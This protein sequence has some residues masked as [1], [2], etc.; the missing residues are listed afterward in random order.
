MHLWARSWVNSDEE[1]PMGGVPDCFL[2]QHHNI[3]HLNPETY[4]T[5]EHSY[6]KPS[7]TGHKHDLGALMTSPTPLAYIPKD[8][9]VTGFINTEP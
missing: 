4:I 8:D 1:Q 2:F 3:Q 5:S 6:Q 9:E 7:G